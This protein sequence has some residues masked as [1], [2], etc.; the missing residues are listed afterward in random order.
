MF[1]NVWPE[2]IYTTFWISELATNFSKCSFAKIVLL[3]NDI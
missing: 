3:F 1:P 2:H